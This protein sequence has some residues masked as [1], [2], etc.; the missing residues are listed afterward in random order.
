MRRSPRVADRSG[1]GV[2]SDGGDL[3][4]ERRL[5]GRAEWELEIGFGKGRYLL[6]RAERE[7]GRGFV[8][9][10]IAGEYFALAA[11]RLARRKL[12]NLALLEGD[13]A[14]FAAVLLPLRR[15]AAIHVYFPD[16]WPKLRHRK[17]RLFA[18]DSVDLLAALVAPGGR[19][20]FATDHLEYGEQVAELLGDYP[21]AAVTRLAAAWPE[22]PRTNYEAKYV[23][24]GRPILRLEVRFGERRPPHPR[25]RVDLVVGPRAE[26]FPVSLDVAASTAAAPPA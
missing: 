11:R 9:I 20:W 12:D 1:I 21:G 24:E 22:G 7:P 10:E 25:G 3:E 15:F 8:G 16:P 4:L 14:Y 6:G 2:L 19:L 13:A 23:A 17:R 26:P 5:A 18:P